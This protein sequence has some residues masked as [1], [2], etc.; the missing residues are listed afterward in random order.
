MGRSAGWTTSLGHQVTK[1]KNQS[2]GPATCLSLVTPYN[3]VVP[4]APPRLRT[5]YCQEIGWEQQIEVQVQ[6]PSSRAWHWQPW[7]PSLAVDPD[8]AWFGQKLVQF[9]NRPNAKILLVLALWLLY[10]TGWPNLCAAAGCHACWGGASMSG[11]GLVQA[12]P[13][14]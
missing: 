6:V 1:H 12:P 14:G 9:Y 7:D 10:A 5:G 3:R 4:V 8:A 2:M 13:H 11:K